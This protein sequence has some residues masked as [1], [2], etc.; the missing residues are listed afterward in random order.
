MIEQRVVLSPVMP[1]MPAPRAATAQAAVVQFV[2]AQDWRLMLWGTRG[3]AHLCLHSAAELT[4]LVTEMDGTIRQSP[5]PLGGALTTPGQQA[6]WPYRLVSRLFR[7]AAQLVQRLPLHVDVLQSHTV[8]LPVLSALNGVMG[9][10]LERWD[11]PLALGMTLRASDSEPLAWSQL[12]ESE[13]SRVVLFLHGL[14]CSEREWQS[15][16]GT[17]FVELLQNKGWQAGWLRYNSGR[18]IWQNG[19]DLANWLEEAMQ[20]HP[21]KEL[22][23]VGHS[24]GGLLMR[25]AFEHARIKGHAWPARVT[26]A[27]Y[28]STPHHGAPMERLGNRANAI[29][30]HSPYTQPLMRLGNIRSAAIKDLRFG[31]ITQADSELASDTAHDDPRLLAIEL[32]EHVRHFMLAADINEEVSDSWLGDGLVPLASA[33]GWHVQPELS[34]QAAQIERVQLGRLGHLAVLSDIR[35]YDALADWWLKR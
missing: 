27:A 3:L 5:W 28:L 6:P 7:Q 11:S 10:K 30:S 31:L 25:S 17:H 24:M 33:L 21:V 20:A 13:K 18:A 2:R 1:P 29:L 9:D 8:A 32:P 23:L 34:V 35:V 16:A 22:A 15:P 4:D 12:A 14:C 19:E 26:R